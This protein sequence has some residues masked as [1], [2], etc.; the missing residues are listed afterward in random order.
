MVYFP[1]FHGINHPAIGVSPIKMD[2]SI[3][4]S[5]IFQQKNQV[6]VRR[7]AAARETHQVPTSDGSA[8]WRWRAAANAQRP[9]TLK[10]EMDD[11][12]MTIYNGLMDWFVRDNGWPGD[13][14]LP[15]DD[16]WI[17]LLGTIYSPILNV[18]GNIYRPILNDLN[19]KIYGFRWRFQ[20]TWIV[21]PFGDDSPIKTMIPGLG[22]TVRSLEFTQ[23]DDPK[24]R[25]TCSM[26]W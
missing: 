22:R 6:P 9:D 3:W 15:G 2:T 12:K 18:F 1:F 7:Y 16:Q 4:S 19:G 24:W 26:E 14:N 11:P 23:M 8:A 13:D 5:G 20:L 10:M 17:G 25:W 21:R